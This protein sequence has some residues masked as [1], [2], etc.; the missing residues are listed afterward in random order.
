MLW[1]VVYVVRSIIEKIELDM[2]PKSKMN[3]Y[4]EDIRNDL[5]DNGGISSAEA[6]FMLGWEDADDFDIAQ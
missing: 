4:S 2:E 5:V 3:F 1:G 6:A